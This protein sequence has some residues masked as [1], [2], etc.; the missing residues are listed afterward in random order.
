MWDSVDI[1]NLTRDFVEGEVYET[2]SFDCE[3]DHLNLSGMLEKQLELNQ[4][5]PLL[6]YLIKRESLS[7]SVRVI[8]E[9]GPWYSLK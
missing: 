9:W 5:L 2:V 1:E 4:E 3:I 7:F 8:L 6:S